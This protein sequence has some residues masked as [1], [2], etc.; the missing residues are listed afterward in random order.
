MSA[1]KGV[2]TLAIYFVLTAAIQAVA[3]GVPPHAFLA[4]P[5][6]S[7]KQLISQ[8]TDNE[9]VADR[10]QRHFAMRESEVVAY[11]KTL[12]ISKLPETKMYDVY[13]VREDGMI[14]LHPR[15]LKAGTKVFADPSGMPVLLM[16]CGNPLVPPKTP[17]I[18]AKVQPTGSEKGYEPVLPGPEPGAQAALEPSV[19]PEPSVAPLPEVASV[20]PI[21]GTAANPLLP[22]SAGP[23]GLLAFLPLLGSHGNSPS[24]QR[25]VPE[26]A[27]LT[28]M[29]I[30]AAMLAARKRRTK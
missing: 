26:P 28:V 3:S 8:V 29:G 4:T 24:S 1:M 22:L 13:L 23:V 10:Y 7:S 21:T 18:Q 25:P 20:P 6:S 15:V 30:G 17:S 2:R 19:F 11:F 16:A 12:H 14:D 5:V 9:T 27:T